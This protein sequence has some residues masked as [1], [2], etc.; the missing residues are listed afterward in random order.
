[1]PQSPFAP[2]DSSRQRWQF[3]IRGML[4]FTA[5]V[6]IGLSVM[7]INKSCW[8]AGQISRDLDDA[9]IIKTGWLGGAWQR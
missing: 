6:A 7:Q 8:F 5:S 1:M 2:A 4:I 9:E 3:S